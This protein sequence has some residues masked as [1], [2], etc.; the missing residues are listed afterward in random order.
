MN[1][2]CIQFTSIDGLML[3]GLSL[4]KRT[5]STAFIFIHGFSS[6]L[7]AGIPL[8]KKLS[9]KDSQVVLFNNRGHDFIAK[10]KKV[11]KA[12]KKG[13]KT[14]LIGSS[15][16]VFTDCIYDIE[17]A[18]KFASERGASNIYLVG[19]ST[20][21]QKTV[22]ATARISSQYT[23]VLKGIVLLAPI[24]DY[25]GELAHEGT[26]KVKN[27]L[28]YA[29]N[30]VQSGRPHDL[31]PTE[32]WHKL[33]DAQR[34]LSL[35]DPESEEEVFSYSQPKKEATTLRALR[36]PILAILGDSDEHLDRPARAVADWLSEEL[37]SLVTVRIIPGGNHN[38]TDLENILAN[39]IDE[40]VGMIR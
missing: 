18:I 2:E 29:R 9:N 5:S 23:S 27:A 40:W 21:C 4:G 30:M 31:M 33:I 15:H 10:L 35:N 34:F 11:D 28:K 38:F 36:I 3:N 25:A 16:E 8:A 12:A 20:G 26:Q 6:S 19:H 39:S 22:F 37:G 13:Y 24:S 14:Q 7:F 1:V 32:I 17:G